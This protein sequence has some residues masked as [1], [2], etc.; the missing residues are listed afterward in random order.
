MKDYKLINLTNWFY[1][2]ILMF[3]FFISI[4]IIVFTYKKNKKTYKK[5]KNSNLYKKEPIILAKEKLNNLK[6]ENVELFYLELSNIFRSYLKSIL[7][8]NTTKMTSLELIDLFKKINLES[9]LIDK[10]V[11]FVNH[12]DLGKYSNVNYNKDSLIMDRMK[13]IEIIDD[14]DKYLE[15]NYF[16]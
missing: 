15:K 8:Y 6:F 3:L 7:Y 13:L 12:S 10:I 2:L 4:L 14:L 5:N 1:S 11:N 9:L 16:N